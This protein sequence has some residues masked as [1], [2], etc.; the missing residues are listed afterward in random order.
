MFEDKYKKDMENVKLSD[1]TKI[2]PQEL[3]KSANASKKAAHRRWISATAAVLLV[4][5]GFASFFP[6]SKLFTS[7][8]ADESENGGNLLEG[9][10]PPASS[11]DVSDTENAGDTSQEGEKDPLDDYRRFCALISDTLDKYSVPPSS[12]SSSDGSFGGYYDETGVENDTTGAP[13]MG[14]ASPGT[15]YSDTNNQVSGVQEADIIKTDGKLIYF[16]NYGRLTIFSADNGKTEK[17]GMTVL[18]DTNSYIDMLLYNGK[19]V[20][21]RNKKDTT[22]A[23]IYS[24]S[25]KG[26]IEKLTTF[27][28]SGAYISCRAV[29]SKLYMVSLDK[30]MRDL[31]YK[32]YDDSVI[33]N[34]LPFHGCDEY[35]TLDAERLYVCDNDLTFTVVSCFDME[36]FEYGS[37]AVMGGGYNVYADGDTLYTYK[38]GYRSDSE[39]SRN[40]QYTVINRFSLSGATP[41]HTGTAWVH[42]VYLNQYSFDESNGYLRV[43][44]DRFDDN[45]VVILDKDL[46]I[47]G[48]IDGMGVN[49]DIKSVRFYGDMAYVVTFRQTDPLYAIDLSDPENPVILSE[50]K[51]PGFSVYLQSYGEGKMFGLGNDADPITGQ[52]KGLKISMF[53]VSDPTN[54][55]ELHT[56]KF[57]TN[58]F[59]RDFS[60]KSISVNPQ[61]NLIMFP[62]LTFAPVEKYNEETDTYY[63]YHVAKYVF[64]FY[65]YDENGFKLVGEASRIRLPEYYICGKYLDEIRGIFIGDYAYVVMASEL[66]AIIEAYSLEDFTLTDISE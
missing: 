48:E 32:D 52:T 3:I 2:N 59:F 37:V 4:C 64:A 46:E 17:L 8:F 34:E 28:Q 19:L 61:K 56:K 47:V 22:E 1:K 33:Y 53:D 11:Q 10:I 16:L 63:S 25:E 43:A 66:G 58:V 15:N 41:E 26:E 51:V 57:G 55:R 29:G 49:E 21:I 27:V 23:E 54:V 60:L 6:A 20:L 38:N 13:E 42:G 36:N 9:I 5:I 31:L 35:V 45:A 12:G 62:Y 30:S 65:S 14:S 40:G 7:I 18:G 24:V 39:V 50:L 44:V